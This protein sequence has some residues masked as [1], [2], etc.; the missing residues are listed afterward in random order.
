MEDMDVLD[1]DKEN[2]EDMEMTTAEDDILTTNDN[3]ATRVKE[4]QEQRQLR[5]SK[6]VKE[7]GMQGITI[8]EK[9][10]ITKMKKNLECNSMNP[11][12]SFAVL[13]NNDLV[14]RSR[15]M[16]VNIDNYDLE[17]FDLLKELET[18]RANMNE[19]LLI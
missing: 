16:G 17:K 4:P 10:E 5:Q 8:A 7:Q 19:R 15:K 2:A 1:T 18:A 13:N 3:Q 14:I 11:K 12:N 6:R 9:A